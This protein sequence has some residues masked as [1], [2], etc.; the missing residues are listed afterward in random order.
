M[1]GNEFVECPFLK[2]EALGKVGSPDIEASNPFKAL[3]SNT[4]AYSTF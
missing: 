4:S 2:R 3:P 1:V